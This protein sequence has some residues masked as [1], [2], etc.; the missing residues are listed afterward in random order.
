MAAGV[1]VN[2]LLFVDANE[3]SDEHTSKR[4]RRQDT[5]FAAISAT[6]EQSERDDASREDAELVAMM[7]TQ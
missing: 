7:A 4:I 5:E 2:V 3:D 1:G 6:E